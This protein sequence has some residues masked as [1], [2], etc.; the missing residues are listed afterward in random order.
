MVRKLLGS[1][2][3]AICPVMERGNGRDAM[4]EEEPL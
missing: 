3:G 4:L 2:P 1:Y